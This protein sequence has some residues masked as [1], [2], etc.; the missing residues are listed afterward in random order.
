MWECSILFKNFSCESNFSKTWSLSCQCSQ[1]GC[2]GVADAG[3]CKAVL[4]SLQTCREIAL[5]CSSV[6]TVE[7]SVSFFHSLLDTFSQ[8]V[9]P[10]VMLH[11]ILFCL[12]VMLSTL[13]QLCHAA[14]NWTA[15]SL[16]S[17]STCSLPA[18]WMPDV[19]CLLC[20]PHAPEV[21]NNHVGCCFKLTASGSSW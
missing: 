12:P 20:I 16:E 9:N 21:Y 17:F 14:W 4:S 1:S 8:K 3:K 5:S 13:F 6:A 7:E 19:V 10:S 11:A 18:M 15:V 2:A